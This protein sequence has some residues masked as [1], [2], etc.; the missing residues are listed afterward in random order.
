MSHKAAEI[1]CIINNALGPGTV[2]E[3]RVHWWFEKFCKGDKSPEDDERSGWPSEVDNDQKR[4][5]K[6]DPLTTMWEVVKELSTEHSMVFQ[7][8]KQIAKLKKLDKC[9]P[10]ELTK[11][12][13]NCHFKLSYSL[14]VC[15]SNERFLYQVVMCEE[16]LVLYNNQRWRT[17]WLDQE[18]TQK[19]LPKPNLHQKKVMVSV[20]WFYA[21][22]IYYSFL[23]PGETIT[24][25][26]Y[27]QQIDEMHWKLQC[28]AADIGQ[29]K[30]SSSS[31]WQCST[32]C[33]TT[34]ASSWTNWAMKF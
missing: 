8:L 19:H 23:N 7:P 13:N 3:H 20:W 31:P 30:W 5:I 25:E 6:A 4:I 10:H 26:K 32:A 1:T 34:T 22:L 11:N 15:N 17:Q 18:E 16:K 14:I 12:N 27:V 28:L 2:N 9:V 33:C 29:H 21:G 24:S